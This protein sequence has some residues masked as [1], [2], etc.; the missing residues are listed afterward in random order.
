[1]TNFKTISALAICLVALPLAAQKPGP[2]ALVTISAGS[3]TMGADAQAL[4]ASVTSGFGVNSPRP[5]HGDF[6]EY[7]AHKV[8]LTH[9]FKIATHL[10]T[11]QEFQ[12]FDPSYKGIAKFPNYAAGVSYR[13]ALAFCAWLT[14]KTGKPYRL[15]TEAEWEYTARA[16]TQT[17]FFTGDTPPA[18]GQPNPWGVVIGEGSPEWVA[19]WYAPYVAGRQVDPTGPLH[20]HFRVVRG[21]GLDYR[22]SK[23]GEMYPAMS[24]YF[25]RP[26]NRASMA[27]SYESA[28]G[29]IGFRVAQAPMPAPH[30]SPDPQHSYMTDVKQT[31]VDGTQGPSPHQP[32][33]RVHELFPNLNGRSMPEVGWRAGLTPGLGI[34]YHNS[35][36]QVLANGDVVAAYY[37]SPNKEDDPDQTVLIMRRRAPHAVS[38]CFLR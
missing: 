28:G 30:P 7:P 8:T 18:P 3:F 33:Y 25:A 4:P 22:K 24:P 34:T 37:N 26:A 29:N 17:P 10:V 6:D 38:R 13:Q 36:I 32:F 9:S 27:P 16:G 12:Q 11:V 15:P 35:A 5:A 19:D 1:M 21:G 14:K 20:G 2:I 31:A 23:P